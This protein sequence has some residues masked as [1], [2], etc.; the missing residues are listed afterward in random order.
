VP[1]TG[2]LPRSDFETTPAQQ[3]R[4]AAFAQGARHRF[5]IARLDIAF[6]GVITLIENGSQLQVNSKTVE[7]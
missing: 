7:K 6:V 3:A 2:P 4:Q 1:A 5:D